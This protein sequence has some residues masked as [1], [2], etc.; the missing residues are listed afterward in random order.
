MSNPEIS[1][2]EDSQNEHGIV[3]GN[4]SEQDRQ[5]RLRGVDSPETYS[6][7]VDPTGDTNYADGRWDFTDPTPRPGS[8]TI[9]TRG[10]GRFPFTPPH[11][12]VILEGT[13]WDVTDPTPRPADR[14][15]T[16]AGSNNAGTTDTNP[17]PPAKRRRP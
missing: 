6:P 7:R 17:P 11:R 10:G 4:R 12:P 2:P 9:V 5:P 15:I 13:A 16:E 8:R 3:F 1:G 14:S